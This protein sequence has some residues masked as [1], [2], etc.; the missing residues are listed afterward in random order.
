MSPS[1][2]YA[3]FLKCCLLT[4]GCEMP[5]IYLKKQKW[6]L[7]VHLEPQRKPCIHSI[8]SPRE[9]NLCLPGLQVSLFAYISHNTVQTASCSPLLDR[10]KKTHPPRYQEEMLFS[11][12]LGCTAIFIHLLLELSIQSSRTVFFAMWKGYRSHKI[13]LPKASPALNS[14]VHQNGAVLK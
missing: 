6:R 5:S 1:E 13:I 12:M 2:N 7:L 14:L 4:P 10:F 11:W 9:E 3:E 8:L